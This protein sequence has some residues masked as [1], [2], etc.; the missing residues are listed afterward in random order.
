MSPFTG[1]VVAAW[2][3]AFG[4]ATALAA[5]A[6]DLRRLRTSAIAYTVFGVLVLVA[7]ARFPSTPDWGSPTAWIFLATAV[8]AALTGGAGWWLAPRDAQVHRG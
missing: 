7:V 5:V 1:R 4:L 2:L 3:L 8:A 6:G